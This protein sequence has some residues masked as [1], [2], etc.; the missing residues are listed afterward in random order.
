MMDTTYHVDKDVLWIKLNRI[1]K[2]TYSITIDVKELEE[3]QIRLKLK[4]WFND[5]STN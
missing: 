2:N 1:S 3:R 5:N 4:N